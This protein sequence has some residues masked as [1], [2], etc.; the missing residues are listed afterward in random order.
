MKVSAKLLTS[1]I[2]IAA[3]TVTVG[4][5]GF[6]GLR[7]IDSAYTFAIDIHGKPLA[8]IA[9]ALDALENTRIK[10]LEAITHSGDLDR[11]RII[12][13]LLLESIDQFEKNIYSYQRSIVYP[14]AREYYDAATKA[15]ET[16]YK[17]TALMIID[18]AKRGATQ[19]DLA[20]SLETVEE[21]IEQMVENYV[22]TMDLKI[23]MLDKTSE[24]SSDLADRLFIFLSAISAVSLVAAIVL[25]MYISGLISRP[26]VLLANVMSDLARTGNFE[27]DEKTG[28]QIERF[29]KSR[30]ESGQMSESFASVISM[31]Q[32]K[33]QTL[34]AVSNG[35]LTTEVVQRSQNDSYGN[36][37]QMMVDRLNFMFEEIHS[38]TSQV[39]AGAK[40]VADGAQALAQG[41]TQQA[42]TIEELSSS[43]SEIAE[44]TKINAEIADRTSKLSEMIMD[45][46]ERGSQ[47][48]SDMIT[49]VSEINDASQ[50]ISKIIKTIDDI[51]FQTNILALNAAVEAARAGQ[52]GKG[53]AVVA[54]EV[55]NLAA[56]SAE[57]ARD[58]GDMIQNSIDRAE[59]GFR[60]AG[61]TAESLAEIVSGINESSKLI[62]EIAKAS[63]EQTANVSYINEGIVQVAQVVQQNSATAQQSAA[64]SEEMSGQSAVLEELISQF[65]IKRAESYAIPRLPGN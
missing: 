37:M 24:E 41:A 4:V 22:H 7:S 55:R 5:S 2:L 16:V 27:M 51:A 52:H 14:V 12:E 13:A 58:T 47:Q 62:A 20:E 23:E 17:P 9:H 65:R 46:A 18:E 34:E 10:L 25:G 63:E 56:K 61:E 49:A 53:F 3:L 64:A 57:A 33:L 1:F 31:M 26:M 15:Y 35:D 60:M 19:V 29:K 38:S 6:L 45:S 8:E 48:M 54:E 43:V 39:S 21:A 32:R 59:Q 42:A 40:Q 44:R 36:A 28:Q 30:D 50:S 11:L